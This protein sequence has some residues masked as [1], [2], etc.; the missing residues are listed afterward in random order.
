[1]FSIIV[2]NYKQK[3]FTEECVK[4]IYDT[5]KSAP[6]EL[7]I[8]NNNPPAS[9]LGTP[10]EDDFTDLKLQHKEVKVIEN[11]NKGYGRAN[12]TGAR[13]AKGEYLLF[14]NSDT[15]IKS[16]FLKDVEEKFKN[17]N[18]GVIGLR[19]QFPTGRYQLSFWKENKFFN[20]IK[21]KKLENAFRN[22]RKEIIAGIENSHKDI[23]TVDWVSGAAMII[24][25]EVFEKVKGFDEEF[26]L[27]YEDSDICRR[28]TEAGYKIYYYP[29]SDIVHYKGE[30]INGEFHDKTYYYS[31]ESQLRYYGKHNG[32]GDIILLRFYLFARFSFLYFTSFK[33]IYLR[34][35]KLLFGVKSIE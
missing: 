31:K 1:M 21:N 6:F 8:V 33:K 30:N 7:I 2:I 24:S 17:K 32:A 13:I 15:L 27:F 34:I 28:I 3:Q 4:S 19:L 10:P 9:P 20:E 25:K 14:L 11:V 29:F 23:S 12:N 18:P 35:L 5:L 22:N 16:D 26:F